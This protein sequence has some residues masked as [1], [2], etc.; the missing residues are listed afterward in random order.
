MSTTNEIY[1]LL[2]PIQRQRLLLPRTAVREIVRY[3]TPEPLVNKSNTPDWLPGTI[4]WQNNRIPLISFEGLCG[5]EIPVKNSRTRIAIM[6]ALSEEIPNQVYAMFV[7]GFPQLIGVKEKDLVV[8][9]E[10]K[11]PD[12]CPIITQLKLFNDRP[13]IPN[14]QY[15]EKKILQFI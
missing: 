6:T 7:E 2:V 5:K 4:D 13:Q 10:V 11:F 15:L 12:G 14:L 3:M 8:D 1:A 9:E